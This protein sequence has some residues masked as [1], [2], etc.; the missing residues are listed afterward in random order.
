MDADILNLRKLFQQ[1]ISY[2]IPQFQRPYTWDEDAQWKPLWEDVCSVA[3][4]L[5]DRKADDR[6][7][8]HFMGA[9][10]LFP[11]PS[12][13]GEVK[14]SIVVDGQQ[15]LTTLQLLIRATQQLF[16]SQDEMARAGRLQELTTNQESYRKAVDD[17]T[18]IRQ[19]SH[20][21]HL[22]FQG[23]I[24]DDDNADL[25]Q[26]V[27]KAYKYFKTEVNGWLKIDPENWTARADALES[28]L[29]EYLQMAVIDLDQDEKPHIIFETLNARG[30]PLK[31][32]DLVKNTVM[33]EARVIDEA[34][35]AAELWG[36]FAD[37]WWRKDTDTG[38]KSRDL[39]LTG[40]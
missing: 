2:Q 40:F 31:Q 5:L 28:A 18:K 11:Q 16:Q 7:R 25:R 9:I 19:S 12:K 20:S 6:I 1:P 21:D 3:S 34:H 10:V 29:T 4:R 24:M 32:S 35:K 39:T 38:E 8:P 26:S 36:L 37:E 17:A 14:K 23:A 22:A 27:S 13:T 30:A 15:R 33:Y